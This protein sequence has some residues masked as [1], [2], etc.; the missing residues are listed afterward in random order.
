MSDVSESSSGINVKHI[1]ANNS[2]DNPSLQITTHKL[3]GQ[4]FLQW[5]Q[6]VKLYVKGKGKISYT[7]KGN[8]Y[9]LYKEKINTCAQ[10]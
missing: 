6:S 9:M 1:Q 2:V 7:R 10:N 4:N 8:K 5:S 3:N